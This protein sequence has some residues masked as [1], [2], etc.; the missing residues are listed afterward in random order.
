MFSS[1][2]DIVSKSHN[3]QETSFLDVDLCFT[4]GGGGG[5]GEVRGEG[6]AGV[7]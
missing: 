6:D 4:E 7:V 5:V 2:S 1:L 3:S